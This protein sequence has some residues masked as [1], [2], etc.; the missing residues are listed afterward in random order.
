VRI[1]PRHDGGL[2]GAVQLA[3]DASHGVPL[4]FAIYA[5]GDPTPVLALQATSVS[6]GPVA[7]SVFAISPPAGAK[8]VR[9]SPPPQ[10]GAAHH[11][12]VL[13]GLAAV[14]A[15]LSFPLLAPARLVGLPRRGVS[16]VAFGKRAGALVTDGPGLGAIAVIE[17]PAGSGQGLGAASGK[18]SAGGVPLPSVSIHGS[19]GRELDTAL[20]TVI[21]FAR[22][23]VQYT[24]LGSVP[25]AAA[26][27]A[28][29]A[30]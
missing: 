24:V 3:F 11:G 29:R 25:P 18:S 1:S 19:R 6:F 4:E 20:G 22:G 28:A 30:L 10:R 9:I 14:R 26:E 27:A 12:K 5:A 21:S 8:V 17:S 23:G 7:A 2:L 15:A 13:R 16:A